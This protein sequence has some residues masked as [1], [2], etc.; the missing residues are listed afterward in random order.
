MFH[1]IVYCARKLCAIFLKPAKK[2][3]ASIDHMT[4]SDGYINKV[5]DHDGHYNIYEFW[6]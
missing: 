4:K 5:C 1:G 3:T 2:M 6:H